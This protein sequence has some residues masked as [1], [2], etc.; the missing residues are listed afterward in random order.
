MRKIIRHYVLDTFALYLASQLTSGMIFEN[1]YQTLLLAGVAL[2]ITTM[3]AKPIINILLL[4][5]NLITFGLFKWVSSAIAL[6]L[7]TLV[8]PGF[9]I[10][11]FLFAGLTT[12]Y[13]DFPAISL[14][15]ILAY[16]GFSFLLSLITSL[17]FWI[18]R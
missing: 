16:I 1:G 11:Q 10:I 12:K 9:K 15:G 17:L 18:F 7:V 2:T 4:P 8:V 5:I 13:F 3:L 14:E 6:Y